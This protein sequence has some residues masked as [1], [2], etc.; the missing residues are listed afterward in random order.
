MRTL[1]RPV[2]AITLAF[3]TQT[4]ALAAAGS[5]ANPGPP[6]G[7][8]AGVAASESISATDIKKLQEAIKALHDRYEQQGETLTKANETLEVL[9]NRIDQDLHPVNLDSLRGSIAEIIRRL[10]ELNSDLKQLASAQDRRVADDAAR[11]GGISAALTRLQEQV[12]TIDGDLAQLR[13]TLA[14]RAAPAAATSEAPAAMLGPTLVAL[15]VCT[16]LLAALIFLAG[17]AQRRAVNASLATAIAQARDQTPGG[18]P[19]DLSVASSER[20][21]TLASR[22]QSVAENLA[23]LQ[24]L[25][26]RLESPV[27]RL[28]EKAIPEG[29]KTVPLDEKTTIP[30]MP[31]SGLDIASNVLWPAPFLDPASPLV[32]WRTLLESHLKSPEHPALPVLSALLAL[33]VAAEGLAPSAQDVAGAVAALSRAL[34]A[35]WDSLAELSADDRQRAS[36]EWIAGIKTLIAT[37]ALKLD[38]REIVPGVRFDPDTMQTMQEGPGNHLNVAAVFSW[39]IFDRSGERPKVLHRARIATT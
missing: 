32:R 29:P 10:A 19:P 31:A 13:K 20:D 28:D 11:I 22:E 7:A 6:V 4:A 24:D 18:L 21:R 36:T 33:R 2:V 3:A 9:R 26:D 23:H 15:A 5:K 30:M 16:L 34:H 12:A 35:Y 17:R 27:R 25:I 8:P 14:A 39:A 37:A 38:I 1:V